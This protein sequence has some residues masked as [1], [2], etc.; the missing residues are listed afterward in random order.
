[1]RQSD[2]FPELGDAAS[3]VQSDEKASDRQIANAAMERY[4]NG[5]DEAFCELY[6]I[7]ATRLWGYLMK[8]V[9]DKARAEDLMQQTLLHM[10]RARG[11]F[12][13]G[14][15]VL[16]WMYA[17]ARNLVIDS[18]RRSGRE[19]AY[20]AERGE[21]RA[22]ATRTDHAVMAR[23]LGEQVVAALEALPDRQRAVYE[24]VK[25]EGL[26]HREV[27]ATLGTSVSAVKSLMHRAL[28]AIR[29]ACVEEVA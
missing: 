23:E 10:H 20:D 9:G 18:G 12:L 28:E 3:G 4:A 22:A 21:Q 2:G 1:M 17:I 25:D 26:T 6:D 24:L 8:R 7:I 11:R 13:A 14:R 5:D 16:P 29:G 27:A 19:V 15:D